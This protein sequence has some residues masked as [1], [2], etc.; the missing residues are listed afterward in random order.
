M[1]TVEDLKRKIESDAVDFIG[2]V[3][4]TGKYNLKVQT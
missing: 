1:K 4:I 2:K 3:Q